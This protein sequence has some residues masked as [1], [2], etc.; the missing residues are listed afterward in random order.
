MQIVL[1]NYPSLLCRNA[2]KYKNANTFNKIGQK[3]TKA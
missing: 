1:W 2:K 3:Y